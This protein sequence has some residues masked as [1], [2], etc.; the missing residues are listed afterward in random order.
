MALEL[1][2]ELRRTLADE[3]AVEVGVGVHRGVV[4]GRARNARR[5]MC[6]CVSGPA[7][8]IRKRDSKDASRS[9]ELHFSSMLMQSA[10]HDSPSRSSAVV[11]VLLVFLKLG[12]TSFGGPIAHLGYFRAEFVERRRWLDEAGYA[13][14]VALCQFL[15]GPASSQVGIA[16][17]M[18]RAGLPGGAGGLA[19]LHPAVGA[20]ADAVRA[21]ASRRSATWRGRLAAR[22]ED[23]RRRGRRPGRV[24]HGAQPLPRPRARRRRG[25]RGPARAGRADAVRPDR[26]HRRRRG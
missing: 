8:P 7:V 9:S 15:P 20:R 24:G 10:A 22:P 25:R 5:P 11:E 4:A 13:D 14:L 19:R 16:L 3:L 1:V 21:T 2:A 26:R 23:R 18:L 12:L 17:G 6:R